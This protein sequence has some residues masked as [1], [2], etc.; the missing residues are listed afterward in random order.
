MCSLFLSSSGV[1]PL[2]P[3]QAYNCTHS[4]VGRLPRPRIPRAHH[5]SPGSVP[6]LKSTQ[7][8]Y[9][10]CSCEV[11]QLAMLHHVCAPLGAGILEALACWPCAHKFHKPGTPK[12]LP[13]RPP[14]GLIPIP[15]PREKA[16]C[17]SSKELPPSGGRGAIHTQ[18]HT[19]MSIYMPYTYICTRIQ[20][21]NIY[22][23]VSTH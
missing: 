7:A 14:W 17:R 18:I 12:R 2:P 1:S 22:M 23:H 9:Q 19:F 6:H 15:N 5:S 16:R 8:I 3:C 11:A 10:L 13:L 4:W 21:H 20:K